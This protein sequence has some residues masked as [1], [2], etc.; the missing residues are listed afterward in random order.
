MR[1][2]LIRGILPI[3]FCLVPFLAFAL[4]L[5]CIPRVAIS[6]FAEHFGTM[7]VLIVGGGVLLFG[8]QMLIAW[9]AL[10]Y[11]GTSSEA[12][13]DRWLTHL[14]QAA[15]WFPM[16]GLIGTVAGI[17]DAFASHTGRAI[18]PR[19]IAPAITATGA[20]LLMALINIFPSYVVI[21]GGDLIMLLSGS[22]T[23]P[24]EEAP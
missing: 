14:A 18:E 3:V 13:L 15:E 17:L 1:T 6:Y 2:L 22:R 16:L 23:K 19:L 7:E 8:V 5:L 4:I 21:L 24:V 12:A 9:L 20:G 11:R 10:V